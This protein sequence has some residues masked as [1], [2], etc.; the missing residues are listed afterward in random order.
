MAY[1]CSEMDTAKI[2]TFTFELLGRNIA[3]LHFKTERVA[4]TALRASW[5]WLT[6]A[7]FPGTWGIFS[8]PADSKLSPDGLVL[9]WNEHRKFF[10]SLTLELL[11]RNRAPL[12][13]KTER[14]PETALRAHVGAKPPTKCFV[15]SWVFHIISHYL[16]SIDSFYTKLGRRAEDLLSIKLREKCQ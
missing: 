1:V 12:H 7:L 13:F 10:W 11:G 9:Q 3:P 5:F 14:V 6:S 8:S 15:S 2:W 4:E 16:K